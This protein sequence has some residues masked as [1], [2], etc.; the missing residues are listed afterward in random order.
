M[1]FRPD[2]IQTQ[3]AETWVKRHPEI[4]PAPRVKPVKET[5]ASVFRKEDSGD[6]REK[7][8]DGLKELEAGAAK[9]VAEK[10]KAFPDDL[11]IRLHFEV[12]E[13]TGDLVLR[14]FNRNTEELL[15][16][17]PPEDLLKI[18]QKLAEL[19]GILFDEKA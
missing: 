1:E 13:E 3:V 12:Y 17:I 8:R 11:S 4:S 2:M 5:E 16:E 19:R 7:R 10:T 9:E 15:R 18:N 6:N 14:I